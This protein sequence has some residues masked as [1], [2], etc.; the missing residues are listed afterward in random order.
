M[1]WFFSL[2]VILALA[3]LRTMTGRGGGNFYVPLPVSCGLPMHE[4]VGTSSLMV[5]AT[6]AAGFMALNAYLSH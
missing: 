1:K 6:A 3:A 2:G 5:A 4:A